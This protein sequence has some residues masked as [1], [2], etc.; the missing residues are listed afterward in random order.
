MKRIAVGSA[1]AL[2]IV[3]GLVAPPAYAQAS[4]CGRPVLAT[5]LLLTL[6]ELSV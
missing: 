5:M 6:R 1:V 4:V 3:A 2:P